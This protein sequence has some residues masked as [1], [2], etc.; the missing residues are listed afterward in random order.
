MNANPSMNDKKRKKKTKSD[1]SRACSVASFRGIRGERMDGLDVYVW[2]GVGAFA[3]SHLGGLG[4]GK[5]NGSLGWVGILESW[6]ASGSLVSFYLVCLSMT[7]SEEMM[8]LASHRLSLCSLSCPPFFIF[9][10]S[11]L[12]HSSS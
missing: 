5:F 8:M 11:K 2:Q 7:Q 10:F 1:C 4:L 6:V 9:A 12:S 3:V